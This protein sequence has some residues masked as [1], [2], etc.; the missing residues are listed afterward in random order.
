M[1]HADPLDRAELVAAGFPPERLRGL[2]EPLGD[3]DVVLLAARPQAPAAPAH[4]AAG[5]LLATLPRPGG[6]PAEV[7]GARAAA[8]DAEPERPSRARIGTALAGNPGL[9]LDPAAAELLRRGDVD[10]RVMIVL[11]ALTGAHSLAVDFPAAAL[12]P[13]GT[14]RRQV[15]VRSVDGAPVAP[16]PSAL[17]GW[18]DGQLPP[19]VPDVLRDDAGC[20]LVG[21]RDPAPSGLLP[22]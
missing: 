4:C 12:E 16:G 5:T 17:R 11:V 3:V 22:A 7:C 10:P 20:L 13:P 6:A 19:Y 8:D 18:L 21:Y 9:R 15:L 2:G 1:L 14:L